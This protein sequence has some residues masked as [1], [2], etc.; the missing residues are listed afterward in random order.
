MSFGIAADQM[1]DG[2]VATDRLTHASWRDQ[3]DVMQQSD[4]DGSLCGAAS[5]M[6]ASRHRQ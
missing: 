4:P 5:H 3:F 6:R 2:S 1:H